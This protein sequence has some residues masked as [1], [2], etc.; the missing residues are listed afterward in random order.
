MESVHAGR[1][2]GIDKKKNSK[3]V[4]SLEQRIHEKKN[5]RLEGIW[6]DLNIN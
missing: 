5:S 2:L 4:I 1:Y 3:H 6:K